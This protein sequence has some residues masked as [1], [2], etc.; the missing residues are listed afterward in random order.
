MKHHISKLLPLAILAA[1]FAFAEESP[2]PVVSWMKVNIARLASMGVPG[3]PPGAKDHVQVIVSTKNE[4]ANMAL[5]CVRF[6][7]GEGPAEACAFAP[8]NETRMAVA[9]VPIKNIDAV[10]VLSIRAVDGVFQAKGATEV[11]EH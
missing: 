8:F 7:D 1:V 10:K 5:V 11:V 4:D 2:A 9:M 6:D 3:I